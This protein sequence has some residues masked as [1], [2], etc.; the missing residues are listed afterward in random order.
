MLLQLASNPN[1]TYLT[2]ANALSLV[3]IIVVECW[4]GFEEYLLKLWYMRMSPMQRSGPFTS[5]FPVF[6]GVVCGS[7]W[8]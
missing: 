4:P 3:S 2:V 1:T 8:S 7:F 6:L 5:C